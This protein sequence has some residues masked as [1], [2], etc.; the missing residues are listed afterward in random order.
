MN[1]RLLSTTETRNSPSM[2]VLYIH[3]YK[4]CAVLFEHVTEAAEFP[5]EFMVDKCEMGKNFT[6]Q[7]IC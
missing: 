4:R 1:L 3:Q 6:F 5:L 7:T 2:M